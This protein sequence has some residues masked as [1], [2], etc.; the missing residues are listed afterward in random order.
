MI[1]SISAEK[2]FGKIQH[3]SRYNSQKTRTGGESPQL[4]KVYAQWLNHIGLCNPMDCNPPGSS[5]LGISQARILEWV[6]ICFSRGSSQL[7]D[8]ICVSHIA[9]GFFI[10]EPPRKPLIRNN[11]QKKKKKKTNTVKTIHNDFPL[12]FRRR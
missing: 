6:Y 11:D 8:R 2:T 5:V 7:R 10:T 9:G 12:R 1:I 3:N 4:N